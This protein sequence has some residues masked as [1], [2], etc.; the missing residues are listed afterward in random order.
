MLLKQRTGRSE[1]TKIRRVPEGTETFIF[2]QHFNGWSQTPIHSGTNSTKQTIKQE[3]DVQEMVNMRN[4]KTEPTLHRGIVLNDSTKGRGSKQIWKVKDND[5]QLISAE[6]YSR[7][8]QFYSGESYI[9][10]YQYVENNS[11]KF[12]IY[13]WQGRTSKRLEKVLCLWP[14]CTE[15]TMR[16]NFV[17]PFAHILYF[18]IQGS[19]SSAYH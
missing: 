19:I 13:F 9:I 4:A 1:W 11:D 18:E 14:Q 17:L 3:F 6:S 12:V 15:D 10:F 2:K 16:I 8:G 7:Y 5:K